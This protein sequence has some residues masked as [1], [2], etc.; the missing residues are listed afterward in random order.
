MNNYINRSIEPLL[1]K[2]CKQFPAVGLTGPRQSG[3]TTLLK[4]LFKDYQYITL[5]DPIIRDQAIDDPELLI[6]T[7]KGPVIIDEIQYAPKLLSY[8]KIQIDENRSK[9]GQYI[10]TGSQQFKLM[11]DIGDTLAGRIGLLQLLP[12][13]YLE[14]NNIAGFKKIFSSTK[15]AFFYSCLSGLYPEPCLAS[16]DMDASLW[17]GSYIQTYLERDVKSTYD[18][19]S[20]REFQA[21]LKLLAANCSQTLNMSTISKELGI[22]VNTVK[23]WISILEASGIVYL[24]APYYKNYGKRITKSPKVYF[25]DLGLVCYLT[26]IKTEEH[27]ISGPMAGALFENYAIMEIVKNYVSKGVEPPT[28][29]YKVDKGLEIDL[30]IEKEFQK[31]LPIEIKVSQTPKKEMT[32]NIKKFI[33]IIGEENVSKSAIIS[34]SEKELLL[35]QNV[36]TE[37]L[38]S[39]LNEL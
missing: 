32:K 10:L 25:Y 16:K 39:I 31:I 8:L 5:D 26:G 28:Y 21:C 2:M 34:L 12:F 17:Y 23:K 30:I 7:F 36:S 27:I 37:K 19:G 11:K 4:H 9:K 33:T 35:S 1:L 20:L 13:N 38:S 29:Y 6:D 3:K 22:S 15:L 24:L 14:L 18:I